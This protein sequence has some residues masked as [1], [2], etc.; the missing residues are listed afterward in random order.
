MTLGCL[1]AGCLANRAKKGVRTPQ[2]D[3]FKMQHKIFD[4]QLYERALKILLLH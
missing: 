2:S 1:T 3:M 4:K